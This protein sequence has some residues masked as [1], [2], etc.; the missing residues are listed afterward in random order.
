VIAFLRGV[1][2][3]GFRRPQEH[4]FGFPTAWDSSWIL[5]VAGMQFANIVVGKTRKQPMTMTGCTNAVPNEE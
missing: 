5:R 3:A 1:E 4:A 2:A